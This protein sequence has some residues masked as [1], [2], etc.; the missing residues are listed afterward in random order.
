[1]VWNPYQSF[2]IALKALK[3]PLVLLAQELCRQERG[4]TLDLVH[5]L[6]AN[7]GELGIRDAVNKPW[8]QHSLALCLAKRLE[9]EK[10]PRAV[11]VKQVGGHDEHVE[12]MHACRLHEVVPGGKVLW[13]ALLDDASRLVELRL[14]QRIRVVVVDR[15]D[16]V[17]ALLGESR[18]SRRRRRAVPG[19]PR[20]SRTG[21]SRAALPCPRSPQKPA[22]VDEALVLRVAVLPEP[23]ESG[24][25]AIARIEGRDI[26]AGVVPLHILKNE[27]K[28]TLCHAIAKCPDIE[29]PASTG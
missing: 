13:A 24:K 22:V 9:Q 11:G 18:P 14:V 20:D 6:W 27:A 29:R 25:L 23:V 2:R 12:H 21:P 17:V 8:T 28:R 4:A 26:I 7:R 1:M 16:V 15:L 3:A 10:R 5:R 19:R